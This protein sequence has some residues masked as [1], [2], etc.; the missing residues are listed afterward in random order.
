M[1][2]CI[3]LLSFHSFPLLL[4]FLCLL[5]PM[6]VRLFHRWLSWSGV[7]TRSQQAYRRRWRWTMDFIGLGAKPV[8]AKA[9]PL[10]PHVQGHDV[11]SFTRQGEGAVYMQFLASKLASKVN[12]KS[13]W[14]REAFTGLLSFLRLLQRSKIHELHKP[15][16]FI[17]HFA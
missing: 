16:V 6:P 13:Y 11:A 14:P 10:P 4:S 8:T 17:T 5:L 12:A 3:L 9:G 7:G 15:P 2:L 1:Q